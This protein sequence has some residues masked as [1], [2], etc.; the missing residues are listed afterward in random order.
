[1]K[2]RLKLFIALGAVALAGTLLWWFQPWL[3]IVDS[4]VAE[5]LP[6]VS[7]SLSPSPSA[8][9]GPSMAA[10]AK[11][12]NTS[13]PEVE[14]APVAPKNLVSGS[15]ISHEHQTTGTVRI[16]ELADG[17]RALRLENFDT[18][19]GPDLEV[20]LSDAAVIEGQAGWFLA[21]DG[22]YVSLGKLKG[23]KG[24]QNYVIPPD[25]DLS[26]FSSI[27]IWCVRF[28]VSFGA[29]ELAK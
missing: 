29:A 20:W 27:S 9:I 5:P 16:L 2:T 22:D 11:P 1:M 23:N 7:S 28:S 25:L 6:V 19:N 13:A 8:S 17:S 10:S 15:F 4:K 18:S 3:L 24:N 12:S 14:D 21:D 26:R